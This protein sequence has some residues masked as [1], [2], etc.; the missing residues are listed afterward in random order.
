MGNYVRFYPE[1]FLKLFFMIHD[2]ISLA[3]Q[4]IAKIKESLKGIKKDI[5]SE[6]KIV[7]D[8]Y[9][10]LKRTLKDLKLQVKGFEDDVIQELHEDDH[11]N[12]L[13]EMRM[14]GEEDLAKATERLFKFVAELPQKAISM[15]METEDGPVKV[16]IQPEMK[17]FVNGRE[18][19]R[20]TIG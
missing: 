19:K 10:D 17:V 11:Y 12:K 3:L 9:I 8:Q 18:E 20:R 1:N 16:N 5:K 4:D 2:K 15:D 14:K 7:N 13:R 6:E